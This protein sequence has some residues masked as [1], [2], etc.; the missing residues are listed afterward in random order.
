MLYCVF[1]FL[2][3]LCFVIQTSI[4]YYVKIGA[5]IIGA[6]GVLCCLCAS[7]WFYRR[8]KKPKIA[9]IDP[10]H[11]VAMGH[12]GNTPS[13]NQNSVNGIGPS[14]DFEPVN[15]NAPTSNAPLPQDPT[16]DRM[17]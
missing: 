12:S 2:S 11:N 6:L 17:G 16:Y 9:L 10:S 14:Y 4:W 7:C 8:P 3:F 1:F 5:F 13:Q 15:L